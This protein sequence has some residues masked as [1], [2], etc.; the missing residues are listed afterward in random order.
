MKKFVGQFKCYLWY[1]MCIAD[2]IKINLHSK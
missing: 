1:D 2:A